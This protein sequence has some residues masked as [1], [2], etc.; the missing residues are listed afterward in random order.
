MTTH[1]RPLSLGG[2]VQ[3]YFIS[4]DSWRRFSPAPQAAL[5][6]QF[7]TLETQMWDRATSANDDAVDCEVVRDPCIQNRRFAIQ[8]VEISPADQQMRRAAGQIVLLL[9]RDASLQVD[10]TCPA[11]WN[12]TV[13]SVAGLTIR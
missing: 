2:A 8:M 12:Q 4:M 10:Q 5:T 3:G 7:C 6:A 1:F 13:G 9:W 11:T